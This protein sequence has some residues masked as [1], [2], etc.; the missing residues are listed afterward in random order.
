MS[1]NAIL[2]CLL[3]VLIAVSVFT[4]FRRS[5]TGNVP[6][7]PVLANLNE[8]NSVAADL[9]RA[10]HQ[11]AL[12]K[13]H[14]PVARGEL[15]MAYHA[16]AILDQARQTYRQTSILDPENAKWWYLLA[17]IQ[18]QDG[19]LEAAHACMDRV[20]AL[21]ENYTPAL[22]RRGFWLLEQGRIDDAAASFS[23]ALEIETGNRNGRIGLARIALQRDE[24]AG[25]AS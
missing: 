25:A 17:R 20:L 14:D 6:D 7:P 18:K 11:A 9:I 4:V 19:E 5:T 2:I 3:A 15:A 21:D 24:S 8:L 10:K 13:P 22:V 16:N 23:Q 1:R 12:N